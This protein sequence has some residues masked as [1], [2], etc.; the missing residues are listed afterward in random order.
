MP[1]FNLPVLTSTRLLDLPDGPFPAADIPAGAGEW[2]RF[3]NGY[4]DAADQLCKDVEADDTLRNFVA[5]GVLFLYRHSVELHLKS[6][7]LDAGDF[8]DDPE[9]VPPNHYLLTLWKRVRTLLLK[10]DP[11]SEGPWLN[12]ADDIIADFDELDPT[13]SAFRYPVD[14]RGAAALPPNLRV[15]LVSIAHIIGELHILLEGAST[16]IDVYMGYEGEMFEEH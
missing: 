1:E 16:Q 13:S 8:L 7:L 10:I 2:L 4:K 3:A 15:D 11:R 6:L 14:T 12:R 5:L 9:K